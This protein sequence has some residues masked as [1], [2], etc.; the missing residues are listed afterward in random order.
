M[1]KPKRTMY[2]FGSV[3]TGG[4]DTHPGIL[5]A[6]RDKDEYKK[7]SGAVRKKATVKKK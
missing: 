6:K 2:E 5:K 7:K 3:H 1:K 4:P